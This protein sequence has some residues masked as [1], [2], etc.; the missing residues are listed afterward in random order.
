ML[1]LN[2]R[3]TMRMVCRAYLKHQAVPTY[4]HY[5]TSNLKTNKNFDFESP[6]LENVLYHEENE[7]PNDQE[8]DDDETDINSD[9][10]EDADVN[11]PLN[12]SSQIGRKRS[13]DGKSKCKSKVQTSK[14]TQ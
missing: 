14:H 13:P 2:S 4:R 10:D 3:L 9:E 6:A 5:R 1:R 7:E 12:L 11:T 8:N